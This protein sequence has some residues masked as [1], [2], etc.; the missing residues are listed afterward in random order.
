MKLIIFGGTGLIGQEFI[1]MISNSNDQ[2]YVVSRNK[3]KIYKIFEEKVTA[4][5][6]NDNNLQSMKSIFSGDYAVIN[7]AGENIGGKLWTAKQKSN[8]IQSR[9]NITRAISELISIAIDKPKVII[10]G[11][12]TGFYGSDPKNQ[13]DEESSKGKGFLA[14]LTDKWEISLNIE[15]PKTTRIIFIRTG[16]VL[17]SEGGIL[18]KLVIPFRFWLGGH[19]GNGLQWIPWIHIK[20]EVKAIKYLL[21]HQNSEGIYN[22][23]SPQSVQMKTFCKVL[24]KIIHRPSWLHI[25]GF[26]VRFFLGEMADELVLS[27]QKV[28]PKRLE[29][30]GFKFQ[31]GQLQNAMSSVLNR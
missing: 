22:L 11:S 4:V 19:I 12:A 27:S 6:W 31:Y 30:E 15:Q 1:R 5:Q 2:I 16:V 21:D 3:E 24:G 8:I 29:D 28:S 14:D 20:D 18:P 25:P 10:Q 23:T 9:V 17:S 13:F 26:I 7:L